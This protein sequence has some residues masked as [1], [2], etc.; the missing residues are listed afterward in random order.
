MKFAQLVIGPAGCGK[1]RGAEGMGKYVVEN[2]RTDV[3]LR[4]H[5]CFVSSRPD[6]APLMLASQSTYCETMKTHCDTTG[7]PVHVVN[8]GT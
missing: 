6:V 3:Q 2:C 1:V 4:V 8:L 5:I 7:R